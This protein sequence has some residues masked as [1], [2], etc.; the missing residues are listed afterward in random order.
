MGW[1]PSPGAAR[2]PATANA[3]TVRLKNEDA[4]AG[5][6]NDP[7]AWSPPRKS[8]ASETTKMN[9]KTSRVSQTVSSRTVPKPNRAPPGSGRS[10]APREKTRSTIAGA[11]TIPSTVTSSATGTSARKTLVKSRWAASGPSRW[12]TAAKVAT[13]AFESAP[14]PSISRRVLGKV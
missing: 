11:K 12:S 8:A 6:K 1:S 4:S 7:R 5:Q 10:N 2:K 3:V 13:N 14:S 9:G